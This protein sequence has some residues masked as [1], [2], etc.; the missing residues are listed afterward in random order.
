M[1]SLGSNPRE[2]R[3]P[4]IMLPMPR[5]GASQTGAL[6]PCPQGGGDKEKNW[7]GCGQLQHGCPPPTA[8]KEAHPF[9]Q[10]VFLILPQMGNSSYRIILTYEIHMFSVT[11]LHSF[12]HLIIISWA[13][14]MSFTAFISSPCCLPGSAPSLWGG[15]R[16]W[17]L[18]ERPLETCV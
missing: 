10:K 4:V 16:T 7:R 12:S 9:I 14:S 11:S 18:E 2:D 8:L 1:P 5:M 3:T 13:A 15:R 17:L 6:T